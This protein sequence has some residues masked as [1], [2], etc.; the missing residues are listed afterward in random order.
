MITL[1]PEIER[2][3]RRVAERLGLTPEEAI[4]TALESEAREA[5]VVPDAPRRKTINLDRVR[6]ITHRIAAR[7]LLDTRA[8]KAI[9][10][11]A[12]GRG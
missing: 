2:L 4:R 10:D 12:W 5:G 1:P 8:P 9:L 3:A 6:A 11:D 7:P